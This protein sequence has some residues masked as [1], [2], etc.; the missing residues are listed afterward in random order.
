GVKPSG[1]LTRWAKP[2]RL[3][4]HIRQRIGIPIVS[5]A[6]ACVG[7]LV[8]RLSDARLTRGEGCKVSL[9]DGKLDE[10]FEALSRRAR[11][12]HSVCV[13]RTAAYLNWRYRTHFHHSYEI[14]VARRNGD[15]LGYIVLLVEDGNGHVID[16]SSKNEPGVQESLLGASVD[17]FRERKAS[18]INAP[19]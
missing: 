18:L 4:K 19:M 8:L 16:L 2:L 5:N 3:D 14:L 17:L 11:R 6:F 7:N 1:G 15:L 12:S 10:E 9:Y 13:A